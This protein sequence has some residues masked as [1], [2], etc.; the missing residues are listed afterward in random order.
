VREEGLLTLMDALRKMTLMPAQQ[1]EKRVPGMRRKGRLQ[2]GADA[3]LV[4]FDPDSIADRSTVLEPL[5]PSVGMQYVMVNG[6]LVVRDGMLQERVYPGQA[7]RAPHLTP[8]AS[9]VGGPGDR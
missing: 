2:V 8:L 1:L 3:D 7:I 4:V 6:V 5:K 9:L